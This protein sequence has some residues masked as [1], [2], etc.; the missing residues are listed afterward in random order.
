MAQSSRSTLRDLRTRVQ[1]NVDA[2]IVENTTGDIS[3]TELDTILTAQNN[4]LLDVID[5][6][7]ILDATALAPA[8]TVFNIDGQTASVDA[9][10]TLTGTVTFDYLV[11]ESDNISGNLTLVQGAATLASNIDPKGGS[12]A[13]AINAVTLN[14]G[15]SV[16]W[17]LSGTAL[18]GAGGAAFNRVFTVTARQPD[19]YMYWGLDA[20]GDP[21]DFNTATA[22]QAVFQ[23]SQSIVIPTFADSQHLVIAQKASDAAIRQILIDGIDQF[24]AF[25]ETGNAFV[26]NAAQYDAYVS[27]HLLLGSVVS[28]KTLQI[29]R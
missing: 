3:A 26:V 6:A 10:T 16:S 8:I 20:D 2:D 22:Q 18:P 5:S 14:A 13:L 24:R 7:N 28:G 12:V 25:T 1:N 9:G 29:V 17:T 19:D 15:D 11:R 4:L 27:N 23:Q 21:T